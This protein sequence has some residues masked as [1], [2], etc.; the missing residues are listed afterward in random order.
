MN[1]DVNEPTHRPVAADTVERTDHE[2]TSDPATILAA[3]REV[4]PLIVTRSDEI[5]RGRRLPVDL[6]TRLRAAGCFRML[7]PRRLG[8]AEA[9]LA[10]HLNL[11]ASWPL[12]TGRSAGP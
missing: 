12:P 7:V 4:I 10:E 1:S 3:V 11:S 6:V 9:D 8:G 2:R 5:E